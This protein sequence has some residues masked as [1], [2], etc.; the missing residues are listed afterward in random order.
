MKLIKSTLVLCVFLLIGCSYKV[1]T[2]AAPAANIYSSSD[3]KIIGKVILV[4]DDS[5]RT[6]Y[7]VKSSSDICSL[8]AFPF[9]LGEYLPTSIKQTTEDVFDKVH[10]QSSMPTKRQSENLNYHEVIYFKLKRFYPTLKFTKGLF[11]TNTDAYCNIILEVIVKDQNSN[12]LTVTT[13][14]GTGIADGYGGNDC[15]G[16]TD[17]LHEAVLNSIRNAMERYAEWLSNFKKIRTFFSNYS[18]K[19][20]I[21]IKSGVLPQDI[22]DHINRLNSFLS[23]YSQAYES[24]DL[25]KFA[26][27][28]TPNATEN[29]RP[30]NEILPNYQKNLEEV[31]SLSFR[32][33]LISYSVDTNTGN[34]RAKGQYFTRFLYAGKLKETN[35]NI[36]MELKNIGNSYQVRRLNYDSQSMKKVGK[37]PKWGPW[38]IV[39]DKE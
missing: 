6:N 39:K 15:T 36:S 17:I 24:K 2:Q 20:M 9:G 28:F 3:D 25:N 33:D 18:N 21:G 31:E 1:P 5:I 16:G 19:S 37:Q 38:I 11:S 4:L 14:G 12:K 35:G 23:L 32:I 30:F 34:I 7:E 29:N 13:I 8:Y 10:Q 26:T 27:F 22:T